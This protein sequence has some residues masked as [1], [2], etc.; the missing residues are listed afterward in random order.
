MT[1]KL[2]IVFDID[3]TLIQYIPN[4]YVDLWESK[5]SLFPTDSYIEETNS[6]GKKTV[7]I[8]R[9]KLRQ[10]MQLFKDDPFFVPALWTYSERDYSN[11]IANVI[12]DHFQLPQDIFLFRYGAED[13]D[14]GT[15][16]P[17]DLEQIYQN[18]PQFNKFNTILVDDRYGNINNESNI[19]NGLCIQPFAP[20]GPE[21]VRE[22][23]P[24]KEFDKQ[25]KDNI[26]ESVIKIA[27][28]IKKD[29][30]GCDDEDYD[31]AFST[32]SVFSEKRVK[33]MKLDVFYQTFA[34][35]FTQVVSIGT[36]FLT[37]KFILIE[38]YDKYPKKMG[39]RKT[40]KNKKNKNKRTNKLQ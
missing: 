6:E 11:A 9:P 39:G 30:K 29:I 7:I 32:E 33:R 13:I 35:K 28:Q 15:G 23:L 19:N 21:K 25:L 5:K 27:Q 40:Q 18:F 36:P 3:E 8:F 2:L 12:I 17:K 34:V 22:N 38:N 10:M 31:A 14:E 24:P 26:F 20:F 37:N 16:I 4:K 1:R